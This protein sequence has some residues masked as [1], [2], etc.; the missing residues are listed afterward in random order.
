[1]VD[2]ATGGVLFIDEAY[3]LVPDDSARDFGHEAVATLLK[4]MEDRRDDLV[5]VAAGYPAQ[6]A[7][8]LDS[9]PGLRSRFPTTISFPDY[10]VDELV[11]IFALQVSTAGFTAG[12]GLLP[13]FGA[14][15]PSP[16]PVG[17]GNGR[18][19]RNVFE[20]AAT[21]QA[22]RITADGARPSS[23]DVRTLLVADLPPAPPT[24]PTTGTGVYL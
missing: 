12:P 16:R 9:N 15:V 2:R 21:R 13:A 19:A 7:A 17:F 4:L 20:D 22:L 5:V 8:F 3:S 23:E 1:V 24:T 6:M 18:W 10:D 11:R 14:L